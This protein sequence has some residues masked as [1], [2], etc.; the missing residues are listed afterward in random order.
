MRDN[1]VAG[2]LMDTLYM[3]IAENITDEICKKCPVV[4]AVRDLRDSVKNANYDQTITELGLT[5]PNLKCPCEK[6]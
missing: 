2:Q 5:F 4:R 1:V 3:M 6:R